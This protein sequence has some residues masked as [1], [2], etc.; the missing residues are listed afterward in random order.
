MTY[1]GICTEHTPII[2]QASFEKTLDSFVYGAIRG[3]YDANCDTM[4]AICWNGIMRSGTGAVTCFT[5]ADTLPI[6]IQ[7]IY[8]KRFSEVRR[9]Y[10]MRTAP[11]R[12]RKAKQI[13]QKVS[14]VERTKRQ[15]TNVSITLL[16]HASAQFIP[17]SY[18]CTH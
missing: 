6:F 4:S 3:R 1:Q 14:R 16:P 12:K 7:D 18:N 10:S 13:T 5:E 2:K 8:T 17:W 15:K 9:K 11:A